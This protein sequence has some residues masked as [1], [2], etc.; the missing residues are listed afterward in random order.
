MKKPRPDRNEG[1]TYEFPHGARRDHF[2]WKPG[3]IKITH[4]SPVQ[5]R[6]PNMATPEE[7]MTQTEPCARCRNAPQTAEGYVPPGTNPLLVIG[8]LSCPDCG[9]SSPIEN[10]GC[11]GCHADPCDCHRE[12]LAA[13]I[14]LLAIPPH[15]CEGRIR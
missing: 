5:E 13:M 4:P 8:T 7:T 12:S 1:G 14:P 11:D 10:D 3:D 2:V 15:K 6:S 9:L